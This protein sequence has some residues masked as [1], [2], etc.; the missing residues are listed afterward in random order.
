MSLN[1]EHKF[2]VEVEPESISLFHGRDYCEVIEISV[3]VEYDGDELLEDTKSIQVFHNEQDITGELTRSDFAY[4][5]KLVSQE[6]TDR[7]HD[8]INKLEEPYE[9]LLEQRRA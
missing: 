3:D 1:I 2:T 9:V 5:Q 4:I 6:I 7:A 8:I